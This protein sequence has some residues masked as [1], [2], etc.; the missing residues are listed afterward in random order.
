MRRTT[1]LHVIWHTAC[2]R[3]PQGLST[4]VSLPQLVV[5]VCVCRQNDKLMYRYWWC[6][7][8][9]ERSLRGTARPFWSTS[10]SPLSFSIIHSI[11][12]ALMYR[13]RSIRISVIIMVSFAVYDASYNSAINVL[14]ASIFGCTKVRYILIKFLEHARLTFDDCTVY[15][16]II[17]GTYRWFTYTMYK[18]LV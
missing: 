11:N 13:Q 15:I 7:L 16:L 9:S 4:A 3:S 18:N 10:K 17:C 5:C 8:T 6:L 1:Q 12:T 2:I 14:M